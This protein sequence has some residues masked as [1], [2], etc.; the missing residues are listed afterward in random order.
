MVYILTKGDCPD[1]FVITGHT[2]YMN[3]LKKIAL[4]V[5]AALTVTVFAQIPA[6]AVTFT[7]NFTVSS[8]SAVLINLDKD[9]I[10]YEKNP[11]KKMYPASLTKIMTAIVVLDHVKDLDNTEYEAP[12]VVFDDL[13]GKNPS[14]V[15]YSRGEVITVRDLMYS[16]LMASAC[17]SAGILA[18]HVG[19]ES[20][21]NFIDMM[22]TKAKEIGCTG[23]NFTNPHGLYDDNQYTNARDMALIAKYAV[24][25]YPK[26]VDIATTTEYTL[27]ATNYHE[28]NWATIHHTNAMV[29][30]GE[31]Y[32]E[33]SRGI[34]TGTLDESGRNLCA[35]ATRDGNNYLLVTLGAPMYDA[36]GYKAN[37]QYADHENI[38]EWAFNTFS[39]EQ[40]LGTGEEI[41]E[42]PVKL[43]DGAE[44]VLLV[45]SEE[46]YAI[47]P[48][49]LDSSN[50]KREIN[51]D[52][53]LDSDG[54]IT[55]PVEK[56]Q[57]LGKYTLSLSGEVLCT[58]DLV[59][60]DDVALSQLEY[61]IMKAKAFVNSL[62]FKLAIA[63]A[64]FMIAAYVAVYVLATRKR[65]KKM[66]R[67][68]SKGRRRM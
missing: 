8:E 30:K 43:G 11:T 28:A 63:I 48:N 12:L 66:K 25:N 19:G 47:W 55:A 49:T 23:T 38:F 33:P 20:I 18:Y 10:I 34:K 27:S 9:V 45:P 32:Y 22:N 56:G 58:V 6:S 52:G 35:M 31:H 40:L 7:P 53:Y 54:S 37:D 26:F 60:K 29:L 42:I 44:H 24:D 64:V 39:Y 5:A 17:E 16:M 36:D 51:T 57:V 21:P 41:T 15:G 14:S 68:S 46:F 62:W 67:V 3:F 4:T 65:K 2:T 50:L 61:N 13:Y 59:A 1:F